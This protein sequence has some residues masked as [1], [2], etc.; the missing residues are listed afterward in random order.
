MPRDRT[1]SAWA[2][3]HVPPHAILLVVALALTFI[4]YAGTLGFEFVYDDHEQVLENNYVHSWRFVGHYFTGHV[5][6]NL[7]AKDPGNYYRPLFL[8]WLR[9]NH[10]LFGLEPWGWHLTTALAHLF[11]TYLVYLLAVRLVRDPVTAGFAALIFGLH[12]VHIEAV[13]WVSGVTEPLLAV[14]LIPSFLCLSLIHI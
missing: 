2:Q 7:Y 11:A 9:V 3:K 14:L 4:V 8:L 1:G 12:P 10:M 5:W 13:A 6:S